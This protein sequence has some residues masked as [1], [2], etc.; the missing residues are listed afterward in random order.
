VFPAGAIRIQP[1]RQAMTSCASLAVRASVRPT[2]LPWIATESDDDLRP[3]GEGNDPSS[4][5]AACSEP[6]G[7]PS[8]ATSDHPVNYERKNRSSPLRADR[9]SSQ[10][11]TGRPHDEGTFTDTDRTSPG[12]PPRHRAKP[13]AWARVTHPDFNSYNDYAVA[14]YTSHSMANDLTFG[15][16][17][18]IVTLRRVRIVTVNDG[19]MLQVSLKVTSSGRVPDGLRRSRDTNTTL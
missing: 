7:G 19:E 10:M 11:S 13:R 3:A 6:L 8:P 5:R 12:R 15:C 9:L 1:G 14:G 2:P 17:K 16:Q 4:G 18:S